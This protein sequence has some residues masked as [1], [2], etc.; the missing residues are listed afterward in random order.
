MPAALVVSG[1]SGTQIATNLVQY[2]WSVWSRLL[3]NVLNPVIDLCTIICTNRQT[4]VY[5]FFSLLLK[6]KRKINMPTSPQNYLKNSS[7]N[8]IR[9][10]LCSFPQACLCCHSCL[11]FA[12]GILASKSFDSVLNNCAPVFQNPD[13]AASRENGLHFRIAHIKK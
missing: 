8:L 6:E 4:V 13:I 11:H 1:H 12:Q 5:W 2:R 3:E 10:Y 9:L 7:T